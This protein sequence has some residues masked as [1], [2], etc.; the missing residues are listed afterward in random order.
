MLK[1]KTAVITGANRG[2]GW[3]TVEAFAKN[4]AT[5]WACMRNRNEEVENALISLSSTYYV[6]I[7]TLYFDITDEKAV[8]EA[9]REIGKKS[10]SIDVLV[11]NAGISV[12]KL[13]SMT[14]MDVMRNVIETNFLSQIH[15]SQLV[16]RYMVKQK[17]G[18]IINVASVAGMEREHGGVAYGSSKAAIIFSTKSLALEL[19][20]SGVRVNSVSPG[21]I[22]TDMWKDRN[23]EL[24]EKIMSETPLRR[25][26]EP[27]EVANA[28]VFLASDL[29]SYITLID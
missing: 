12:E 21:F 5:I 3:A 17:H 20:P 10:G 14:S 11:N 28:I 24:R 22:K 13:F 9:I 4:H 7:M 26:G 2:I 6:D 19:G 23:E 16:S 29:S 8:K 18:S 15:L 1:G 25:Q 27:S